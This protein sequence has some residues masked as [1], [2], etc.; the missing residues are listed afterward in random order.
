VTA[1]VKAG[2]PTGF[3]AEI[4]QALSALFAG[5]IRDAKTIDP[6]YA[7]VMT[8]A[9]DQVIRSGKR[10]RPYLTYLVHTG[11]GGARSK[12]LLLAAASQELFHNFLLLHDDVIDRDLIRHGAPNI[13]SIYKDKFK[14]T[15]L[16]DSEA[17]HYGSSYAILVGNAL[18]ALG[19]KA[20]LEA[21]FPDQPKL[22]AL[23]AI[24]RM[25]FEEM[26]GEL[27]DVSVAIPGAQT[28]SL[29]R[30]LRI[31]RYKTASYTF[32]TPIRVGALLAEA[33]LK[34]IDLLVE[35]G[36]RTGVV[37]QLAD[38]LLG[39]YGSDEALGKPVLSDIQEGKHTILIHYAYELGS[40][41][42]LQVLESL[43]GKRTATLDDLA[44]MR[45]II[46][47]SG[48]RAKTQK[49]AESYLGPALDSLA[50]SDLSPDS[51]T[52]LADLAEFSFKR[53]N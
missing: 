25:K 21:D 6:L 44:I 34:D 35:Y 7:E 48:A 14:A 51:K 41:A 43:W 42:Q 20:I 12:A 27:A 36:R 40:P 3:K 50:R 23:S 52:K 53:T 18:S 5:I 33:N 22:K 29:D 37:F 16:S 28:P 10:A 30:L 46:T 32:E 45:D 9:R 4:D 13:I 39:V 11:F 1:R 31:C 26:G 24:E 38:D 2:V 8:Y 15:G 47:T 19:F 17:S 49:L